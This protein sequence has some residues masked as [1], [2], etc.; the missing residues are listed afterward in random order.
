MDSDVEQALCL[1]DDARI[2]LYAN[3]PGA[4]LEVLGANDGHYGGAI[5][6]VDYLLAVSEAHQLCA[7]RTVAEEWLQRPLQCIEASNRAHLIPRAD[8]LRAIFA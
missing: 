6:T 1:K 4:A 7:A 8:A 5:H 3:R 2:L